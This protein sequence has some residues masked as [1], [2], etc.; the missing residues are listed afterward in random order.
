[1]KKTIQDIRILSLYKQHYFDHYNPNMDNQ[2]SCL[3]Y[4]DGISVTEIPAEDPKPKDSK[5]LEISKDLKESKESKPDTPVYA[6][7]LFE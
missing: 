1:M 3:G 2:F 6:S 4:Y 5:D 7:R